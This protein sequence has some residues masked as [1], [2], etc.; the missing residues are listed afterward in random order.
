MN[1]PK[2]GPSSIHHF[3]PM[4]RTA[5]PYKHTKTEMLCSRKRNIIIVF[6]GSSRQ[7]TKRQVWITYYKDK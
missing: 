2:F 4:D 5:F 7:F 6:L 1:N 3:L